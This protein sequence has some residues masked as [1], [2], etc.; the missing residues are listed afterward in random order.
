M[1]DVGAGTKASASITIGGDLTVR[2]LGFGA[3]RITGPGIWGDPPDHDEALRVL[4]RAVDL[5]VNLIDT[6]DSY[7]PHV[8]ERLI[9]EALSPY[10]DDL[11]IATKGGLL[12]DG[13]N[14]W[15]P[16]G[17]PEHL[18]AVC[19]ESLQRLRLETIAIYQLHR[20]DPRVPLAD[21]IGALVDLQHEGKIHHLGICNVT[22]AHLDEA[23]RVA[24]M[25]SV[26]NRFSRV[27]R[28]SD[29]LVDRCERDGRAFLPWAPLEAGQIGRDAVIGAIA[30]AHQATPHQVAIAWLLARSPVIVPIPGTGSTAH[31]EENMGAATLELSSDEIATLAGGSGGT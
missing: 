1:T 8:S 24:P 3:M 12:R 27:D 2:R 5:G 20:P 15:R 30:R 9:A 14:Q 11:V 25:V 10:P 6:A 19:E 22:E 23:T 21:S 28:S 16:D 13:P 26:Q 17:R 31:L 29:S 18:R 7:G 4:R